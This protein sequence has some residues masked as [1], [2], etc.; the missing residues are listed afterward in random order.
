[1]AE[2]SPTTSPPRLI[3]IVDDDE[4]VAA[5]LASLV[6]SLDLVPRTFASAD[7]YLA[8][9]ADTVELV[10]SDVQMPGVSGIELARVLRA[11]GVPVILVTAFPTPDVERQ[12]KEEG[13]TCFMRKPFEPSELIECIERILE[14][15]PQVGDRDTNAVAERD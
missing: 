3:A 9:A 10:I 2:A 1:M 6:E 5:A 15:Q 14:A 11:R 7:A 8:D 4:D 13:V 12:A